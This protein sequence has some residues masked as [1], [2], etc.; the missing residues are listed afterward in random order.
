MKLAAITFTVHFVVICKICCD[1][2]A[3]SSTSNDINWMRRSGYN[4][5]VLTRDSSLNIYH[6]HVA[7]SALFLSAKGESSEPEENLLQSSV[8]VKESRSSTMT[9]PFDRPSLALVDFVTLV[10]FAAIGT[11]SHTNSESITLEIQK[12]LLTAMPFV[13]SWFLT[14][15]FT[16]VYNPMDKDI[17]SSVLQ[18]T[19]GWIIA[20]PIG[21][22]LRGV[23]KGYMPP[24][25]FVVVTMI[26][27][28]VL[29]CVSRIIY[30]IIDSK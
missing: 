13:V 12:V 23:I 28:L 19:K 16:G 15:T 1:G 26:S 8:R 4:T 14:S 22:I 7:R 20:I 24:I 27:T 10:L 9:T 11:L 29:M 18:T 17:K 25:P 30:N 21:C 5:A 2:F 3:P 6:T